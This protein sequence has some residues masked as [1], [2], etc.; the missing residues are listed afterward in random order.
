M[1]DETKKLPHEEPGEPGPEGGTTLEYALTEIARLKKETVSREKYD[2]MRDE[3]KRLLE[4]IVNGDIGTAGTPAPEPPKDLKKLAQEVMRTHRYN[5]DYAKAVLAYR[6]EAIKQGKDDP[7]L[8]MGERAERDDQ[9]AAKAQRVADGLRYAIERADAEKNPAVFTDTMQY[10]MRDQP[11][12][13]AV[14]AARRR[15]K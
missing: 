2:Q 13:E 4:Q 3:N 5:V 1:E 14:L 7:F 8:P 12:I 10:I 6:D 9:D 11:G 15:A